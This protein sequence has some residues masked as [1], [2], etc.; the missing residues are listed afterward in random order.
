M[1]GDVETARRAAER[2]EARL[3]RLTGPAR[4]HCEIRSGH[5]PRAAPPIDRRLARAREA[6]RAAWGA[7]VAARDAEAEPPVA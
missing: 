1:A 3:A 2:A 6:F 5:P 7:Y 4:R